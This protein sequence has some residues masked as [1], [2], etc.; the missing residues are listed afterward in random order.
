MLENKKF[1]H[2]KVELPK[3]IDKNGDIIREGIDGN[4][5]VISI[6]RPNKLNAIT[7]Q[8]VKEIAEA[9]E[10]FELDQDVRCV[11]LRGI[12][13]YTKKPSFSTGAD[14]SSPLHPKIKPN[15]PVHMAHAMHLF[16]K[17]FDLIDEFN[18]PLIG[19]VDGYALGGG[20]ELSLVCDIIIATKRSTFGFSEILRGIFPAGGGTQRMVRYIGLARAAKMLYFGERYSAE[21]MHEWG[22]VRFLVNEDQFERFVHEKAQWLGNAPTIALMMIK[23]ALKLGTQVPLKIGLQFEQLGFGIN[24]ASDDVKEGINAFLKKREP[25]FKGI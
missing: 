3:K 5:A 6:N 21:E 13:E 14:L 10:Q 17:Y 22:Y 9:L 19:A 2:I 20:C 8:T 7:V 25:E 4:Y 1:E 18:K 12:K 15:I 11:V 16:H 24:S 23:K